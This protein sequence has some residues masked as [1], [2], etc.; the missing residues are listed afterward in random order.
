MTSA[1]R[2]VHRM[3]G[4]GALGALLQRTLAREQFEKNVEVRPGTGERVDYAVKLPN[5][6][7]SRWLPL[8]AQFPHEEYDR[9]IDASMR[10][11]LDGVETAAKA[12]EVEI[13]LAA[14]SLCDKH[15]QPPFSADFAV[16]FVP[17]EG[18]YAEV[19]RRPGLVDA[20]QRDCCVVIAGPTALTA[21]L[22]GIKVGFR[23]PSANDGNAAAADKSAVQS[24]PHSP[25]SF[26][27]EN[28]RARLGFRAPRA[29]LPA[30]DIGEAITPHTSSQ[31]A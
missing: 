18:L 11:D 2:R 27:R 31:C 24:R 26:D 28:S 10:G 4:K 29:A 14:R 7:G 9:L 22:N 19:A 25:E 8:G 21:L 6:A 20:L 3:S 16:L 17:L 13:R 5:P 15:L 12:L 23:A 1:T 30:P